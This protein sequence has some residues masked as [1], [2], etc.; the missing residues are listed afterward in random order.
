MI[1]F[2]S[3]LISSRTLASR[4]IGREESKHYLNE[5]SGI[6]TQRSST[7]PCVC[8]WTID[9]EVRGPRQLLSRRSCKIGVKREESI[10]LCEGHWQKTT[11][12]THTIDN[13]GKNNK[14]R[15]WRKEEGGANC[16]GPELDYNWEGGK[17]TQVK[18]V[19]YWCRLSLSCLLFFLFLSF[20]FSPSSP[21]F[22]SHSPFHPCTQKHIFSLWFT[23]QPYTSIHFLLPHTLTLHRLILSN[24]SASFAPRTHSHPLL[25]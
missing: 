1:I 18:L 22:F 16:F 6:F 15:W 25:L 7:P 4:C 23:H 10:S 8:D 11:L 5:K 19:R 2:I 3:H 13:E 24:P 17:D 9:I 14:T 20:L 12:A 21:L